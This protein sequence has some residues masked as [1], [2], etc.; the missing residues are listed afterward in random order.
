MSNCISWNVQGLGKQETKRALKTIV[1]KSKPNIVVLSG[2]KKRRSTL[3]NLKNK[4]QFVNSFY[5]DP[6]GIVGALALWWDCDTKRNGLQADKN[7]ML[8]HQQQ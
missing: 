3:E 5:V 2:T 6:E 4:L 7:A 8:N 1:F